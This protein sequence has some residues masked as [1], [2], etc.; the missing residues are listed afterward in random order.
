MADSPDAFD[1]VTASA[2][3]KLMHQANVR[4][5]LCVDA[6]SLVIMMCRGQQAVGVE[7]SLDQD[8][9]LDDYCDCKRKH[10]C[11]WAGSRAEAIMAQDSARSRIRL[12][13]PLV[14][15]WIFA[16]AFGD[17]KK[18]DGLVLGIHSCAQGC[19]RGWID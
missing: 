14:G 17:L 3:L 9:A 18:K 2:W 12:L 15:L 11:A 1:C 10:A 4:V 16:A 19:C 8:P 5:C 6:S 13:L 7:T